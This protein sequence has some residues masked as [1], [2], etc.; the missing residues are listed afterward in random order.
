MTTLAISATGLRN[1][2]GKAIRDPRREVAR[3]GTGRQARW[4]V[5]EVFR[6][7]RARRG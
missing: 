3:N 5:G 4:S 6:A 7:L 2:Y 1:S